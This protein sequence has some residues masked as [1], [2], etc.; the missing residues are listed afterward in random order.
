MR[1]CHLNIKA[2]CLKTYQT[3]KNEKFCIAIDFSLTGKE[4][5]R[6]RRPAATWALAAAARAGPAPRCP[7]PSGG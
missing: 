3:H 6:A 7:A 5:V 2:K 1:S 4:Q